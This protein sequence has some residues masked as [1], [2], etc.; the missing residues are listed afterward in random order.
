MKRP[1]GLAPVAVELADE[2]V[3]IYSDYGA[4]AGSSSSA[5]AAATAAA[6]AAAAAA[7]PPHFLQLNHKTRGS[8]S[9]R[10]LQQECIRKTKQQKLKKKAKKLEKKAKELKKQYLKFAT[11][12]EYQVLKF[13]AIVEAL[14]REIAAAQ[15]EGGAAAAAAAAGEEEG[16]QL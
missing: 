4:A 12:E 10:C 9:S 3:G 1:G 6:A 11:E 2:G 16:Q 13:Q 15:G 14:E 5:A 8:S 7:A